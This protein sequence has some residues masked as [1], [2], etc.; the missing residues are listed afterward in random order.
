MPLIEIHL[1]EGR[2]KEQKK[3]LLEAVT[4]AV[5]ESI[6]APLETIRVW[7]Q[8]FPLDEYMVAGVLASE[9]NKGKKQ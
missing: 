5:H 3:A 7:I 9:K 1:L 2:T 8:E 6:N 4:K